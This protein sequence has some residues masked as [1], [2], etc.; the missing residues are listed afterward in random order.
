MVTGEGGNPV[1]PDPTNAR[2][3]PGGIAAEPALRYGDF[4]TLPNLVSL[5]RIAGVSLALFL[6]A[7]GYPVAFLLLGL[8]S[9]LSDHLDGYLARRLGMSTALGALLDQTA[10]S[11]TISLAMLWLIT[12]GGAPQWMLA[13]FLLREFWVAAV[14]RHAA[15]AGVEIPSRSVGK[16]A[17]AVIYWGLFLSAVT[18]VWHSPQ[19]WHRLLSLAGRAG[20]YVGLGLSCW[21]A[22]RYSRSAA[23]TT[24]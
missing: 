15:H 20:I 21:A 4:L 16:V 10:D 8:A 5:G 13:V 11:Y 7:I 6:Y 18:V 14:R 3:R 1:L 2:I 22:V 12:A 17:T 23:R 9:C 19:S 24:A